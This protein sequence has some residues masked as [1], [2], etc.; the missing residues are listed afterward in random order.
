MASVR[1]GVCFRVKG[2]LPGHMPFPRPI[3]SQRRRGGSFRG[4]RQSLL[5]VLQIFPDC[6]PRE[7]SSRQ[8]AHAA[9]PSRLRHYREGNPWRLRPGPGPALA[10][11]RRVVVTVRGIAIPVPRLKT[12][13]N[14][15]LSGFS[16]WHG[17]VAARERS[18]ADTVGGR[19]LTQAVSALT[20]PRGRT[21]RTPNTA[22]NYPFRKL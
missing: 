2:P 14:Q 1:G 10:V 15:A 9:G 7:T 8:L 19:A 6:E 16:P 21:E 4:F 11:R 18:S 22:G 20:R 3:P 12:T 5:G 13:E 17:P